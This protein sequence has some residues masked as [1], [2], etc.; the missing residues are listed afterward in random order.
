MQVR[1]AD[2]ADLAPVR[3]LCRA[4]RA[5][6]VERTA[7]LP[8]FLD[9]HYGAADYEAILADLPRL[10]ARPDGAILVAE[11]HGRVIGCIMTRR[12]DDRTCEIKRLY[13]DHAARGLGAA[14]ALCEAALAQARSDG[15]RRVKLDTL[16]T[17]T[18]AIGL[19][20]AM[21]FTPCGPYQ[22]EPDFALP[23]LRFFEKDL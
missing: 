15:Y 19:Y 11:A 7:D 17:L 6:L 3:D 9:V 10:H 13:V 14:R 18:E 23:H 1:H 12:L 4:Y 16:F 2:E 5:F 8:G 20:R 21:G 22:P